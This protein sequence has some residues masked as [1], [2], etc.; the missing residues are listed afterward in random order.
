MY[1]KM[2]T[3]TNPK[4]LPQ[5]SGYNEIALLMDGNK[6]TLSTLIM[7]LLTMARPNTSVLS[8][9]VCVHNCKVGF[10]N[11]YYATSQRIYGFSFYNY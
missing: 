8:V 3:A 9:C 4:T 5:H 6:D 11:N 10:C 1:D 7:S 2:D